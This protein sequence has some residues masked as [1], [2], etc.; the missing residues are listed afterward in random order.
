VPGSPARHDREVLVNLLGGLDRDVPDFAAVIM[1]HP[2]SLVE[3]HLDVE[4]IGMVLQEPA[5]PL[6]PSRLLVSLGE[7]NDV[8]RERRLGAGEQEEGL[9][10]GRGHPLV[11]EG[12]AS[13]QEPVLLQGVERRDAPP[14]LLDR[15]D[16]DVRHDEQRLLPAKTAIA[17]DEAAAAG[18]GLEEL[19]I[20]ALRAQPLRQV[21]GDARLVA[22]R[23]DG[24]EPH[25]GLEVLERLRTGRREVDRLGLAGEHRR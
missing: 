5:H 11:V 4:K 10:L 21:G 1:D 24:I 3:R 8:A 15:H 14:V 13:P 7:E 20:E 6:G 22:R 2:A 16:V 19:G 9:E 23:V 12:A 25:Q 18:R 17:D